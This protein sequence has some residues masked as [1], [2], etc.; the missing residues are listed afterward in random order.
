MIPQE[1][2][3]EIVLPPKYK[4]PSG[5]PAKK[6]RGK[7]KRDKRKIKIIV[8]HVDLK[9][10]IDV[11]VGNIINDKFTDVFSSKAIIFFID[12]FMILNFD[13]NF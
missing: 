4:R 5:R 9:V 10:T 12:Y 7:S 2:L 11:H 1:I 13:T 8:V 6:D 3:E